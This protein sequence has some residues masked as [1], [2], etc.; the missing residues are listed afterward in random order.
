MRN[1]ALFAQL[2][3]NQHARSPVNAHLLAYSATGE[4]A[5]AWS[6]IFPP[7]QIETAKNARYSTAN[8]TGGLP[9]LEYGGEELRTVTLSNIILEG[10]YDGKD[11][12]GV[13]EGLE[14]LTKAATSGSANAI[15]EAGDGFSFA[16]PPVLS[17]V[18]GGRVVIAPCVV[19][20]TQRTETAW[21]G[22]GRVM[23][24]TVSFTLQEISTR[25]LVE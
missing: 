2:P 16:S 8:I 19:L 14:R 25:D 11:V 15:G 1:E 3:N 7:E 24:A 6:F 20:T 23:D 5:I 4:S 17:F 21:A 18:L 22:D 10:F 12:S 9:S 13:A